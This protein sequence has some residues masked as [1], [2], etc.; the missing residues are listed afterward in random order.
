MKK[1]TGFFQNESMG[2]FKIPEILR[3]KNKVVLYSYDPEKDFEDQ[4]FYYID[5]NNVI[6]DQKRGGLKI[7]KSDVPSCNKNG[8]KVDVF[9]PFTVPKDKYW[10]MGDN[11]INSVD[12]R[13]WGFVDKSNICGKASFV[14][15]SLDSEEIFWF[16][17]LLKHPLR[18]WKSL[19][20]GRFFKKI[21]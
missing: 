6:C 14:I 11:R 13:E 7:Y 2:L 17:E 3:V 4:P 12:S 9:G 10:A 1:S 20:W 16:F 18:F 15:W 5:Y 21:V 8:K 19:R